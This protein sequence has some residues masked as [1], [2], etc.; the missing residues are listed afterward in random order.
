MDAAMQTNDSNS[1]TTSQT[2]RNAYENLTEAEFLTHEAQLARCAI[3]VT[4]DDLKGSL[5]NAADPKLWAHH[6][7]W[8]SVGVAAA[9]GF[10]LASAVKG[11]SGAGLDSLMGGQPAASTTTNPITAAENGQSKSLMGS[12]FNLA[13]TALEAS[14]ISAIRAEGIS[15]AAQPQPSELP[16]DRVAG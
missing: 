12:L 14:L 16:P 7:P 15:R 6:H 3:S 11:S 10:T 2:G 1:V 9:A 8:M 5:K 13:R 4:I